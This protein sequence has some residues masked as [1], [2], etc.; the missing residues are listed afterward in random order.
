MSE[1]RVSLLSPLSST[2]EARDEALPRGAQPAAHPL[3]KA[4]N[5]HGERVVLN[6]L[7]EVI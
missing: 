7:R 3:P 5:E 1:T 2:I 4:G 6:R